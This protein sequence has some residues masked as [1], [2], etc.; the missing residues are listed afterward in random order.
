MIAARAAQPPGIGPLQ[1]RHAVKEMTCGS[2][3]T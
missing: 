2:N 1:G 3:Q